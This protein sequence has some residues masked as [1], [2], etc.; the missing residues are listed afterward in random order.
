MLEK[1]EYIAIEDISSLTLFNINMNALKRRDTYISRYH[2]L[3]K[4]TF[5]DIF[6][7]YC[8]VYLN[9]MDDD[10]SREYI[11]Q[12]LDKFLLSFKTLDYINDKLNDRPFDN[13]IN[14]LN[15]IEELIDRE[16]KEL[17]SHENQFRKNFISRYDELKNISVKS[18]ASLY[19]KEA[20]KNED[21]IF[22]DSNINNIIKS[23][24]Q[25]EYINI[26]DVN[27]VN[28]PF[29][30]YEKILQTIDKKIYDSVIN[31]IK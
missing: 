28:I 9:R 19:F 5:K 29:V 25:E 20:L 17:I 16:L 27:I 18:I 23:I 31:H 24:L 3:K 12:N 2:E 30:I 13:F 21:I 8:L 10:K 7:E 26:L 6:S 22:E 4:H 14:F 1:N 11:Q 15:M